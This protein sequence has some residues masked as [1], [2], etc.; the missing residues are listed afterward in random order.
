MFASGT[1]TNE[2]SIYTVAGITI[3]PDRLLW[4]GGIG[5]HAYKMSIDGQITQFKI[6][7]PVGAIR[8]KITTGPGGALWYTEQRPNGAGKIGRITTDGKVT[9]FTVPT[10]ASPWGITSGPDGALWFTECCNQH[11]G[12]GTTPGN[13]I[14]RITTNGKITEFT[15]PT[16]S[17]GPFGITAGPDG[18][19][20]FSEA[21]KIGRFVP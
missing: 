15:L 8:A 19:L 12:S 5:E 2:F 21:G 1:V 6:P 13:K 7:A 20:W 3:G 14:G 18:A 17:M 9:E 10:N 4:L 16:G 11:P